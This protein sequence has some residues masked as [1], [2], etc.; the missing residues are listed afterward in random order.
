M[1]N[2]IITAV[3]CVAVQIE[4]DRMWHCRVIVFLR[5]NR[6]GFAGGSNS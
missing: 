2:G 1:S 6:P 5:V 3:D 4:E